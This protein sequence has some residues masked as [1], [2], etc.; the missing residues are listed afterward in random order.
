MVHRDWARA[1]KPIF[2]I[3]AIDSQ[4]SA[5]SIARA[6]SVLYPGLL[7]KQRMRCA[8]R[9]A[10]PF[11][12]VICSGSASFCVDVLD[13]LRIIRDFACCVGVCSWPNLMSS[14][15]GI[16]GSIYLLTGFPVRHSMNKFEGRLLICHAF[17]FRGLAAAAIL[18]GWRS[19]EPQS[20]KITRWE[21]RRASAGCPR[22]ST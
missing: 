8:L 12:I 9:P 6:K 17:S 4:P 20:A 2:G 14:N 11:D 16:A 5:L 3:H 13:L 10:E 1:Q 19:V 7:T 18:A 15:F 21:K 22:A